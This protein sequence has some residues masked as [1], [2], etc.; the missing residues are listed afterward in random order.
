MNNQP[1]PNW[2]PKSQ[3]VMRDQ[4][5]AYDDLGRRC[6]VAYPHSRS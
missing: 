3:E 2:D 6:P 1:L 4:P 5:A